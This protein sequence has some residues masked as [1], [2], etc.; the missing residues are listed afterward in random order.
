M[1]KKIVCQTCSSIINTV[2]EFIQCIEQSLFLFLF[3][4]AKM[5]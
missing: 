1:Q 2:T 4:A 3:H 5:Q